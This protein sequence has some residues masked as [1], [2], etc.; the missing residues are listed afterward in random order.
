MQQ[1]AA[2]CGRGR[3]Q[4]AP[5][6]GAKRPRQLEGRLPAA[7]MS[8]RR[9][10]RRAPPSV[11]PKYQARLLT[12][13][14]PQTSSQPMSPR[15]ARLLRR[16]LQKLSDQQQQQHLLPAGAAGTAAL[17]ADHRPRKQKRRAVHG[18]SAGQC[19]ARPLGTRALAAAG[20]EGVQTHSL[21]GAA[22]PQDAPVDAIPPPY[23][24]APLPAPIPTA[25]AA[26]A[27]G[28]QVQIKLEPGQGP[29]LPICPA[30][31]QRFSHSV[32]YSTAGAEWAAHCPVGF[33]HGLCGPDLFV[34]DDART[35]VC[36]G[37]GMPCQGVLLGERGCPTASRRPITPSRAMD[38]CFFATGS[39]QWFRLSAPARCAPRPPVGWV[40]T[41]YLLSTL[42][43]D[44]KEQEGGACGG[45]C[46]P[47]C[48][49]G[50]GCVLSP[51]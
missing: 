18:A 15:E 35:V 41:G 20:G 47:A 50:L 6:A 22:S 42:L 37:Y 2:C 31:Q 16:R 19:G 32:A 25:A 9:Q 28:S 7:T 48:L 21:T 49:C 38:P 11:R 3:A 4:L 36:R 30:Q 17:A 46:L 43:W 24:A 5:A 45:A 12:T 44:N 29:G 51:R 40:S 26:L 39:R 10:R 14:S 1:L 23:V 27:A 13:P 34:C 33:C 8:R